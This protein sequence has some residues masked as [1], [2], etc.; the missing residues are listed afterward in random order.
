MLQK[1]IRASGLVDLSL[2]FCVRI[3]NAVALS[4]LNEIGSAH[5]EGGILSE[6]LE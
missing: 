5:A 4:D 6:V 1:I 3:V 2:N